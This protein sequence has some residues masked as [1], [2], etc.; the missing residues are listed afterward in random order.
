MWA[1]R[2]NFIRNQ[3][4]TPPPTPGGYNGI[5]NA[6]TNDQG[7]INGVGDINSQ[8]M[9]AVPGTVDFGAGPISFNVGDFT[10]YNGTIW[11]RLAAGSPNPAIIEAGSWDTATNTP[12]LSDSTPV[13]IGTKYVA[14]AAGTVDFGTVDPVFGV[15]GTPFV[16]GDYVIFNGYNWQMVPVGV[17]TPFELVVNTSYSA[18]VELP[19][20]QCNYLTVNWGDGNTEEITTGAPFTHTYGS[21]ATFTVTVHGHSTKYSTTYNPAAQLPIVTVNS[22]GTYGLANMRVAFSG[23]MNL[24][25]VPTYLPPSVKII[26]GMFE[27]ATSFNQ[28]ISAWNTINVTS[29]YG[30]FGGATVFNQPLNTWNTSNITEMGGVFDSATVFNQPLSSW[31]TSKVTN[32]GGMFENA[33]AF[34]QDISMWDTSKVTDMVY[35]FAGA[36]VFNQPLNSWNM[37]S[38]TNIAGMFYGAQAFNHPL[39]LWNTSNVITI[40]LLFMGALAFNQPLNSWDVSSVTSMAATFYNAQAFNQSLNSWNT[41]KV[42]DMNQTFASIGIAGTTIFNQPLSSW[43]VSHVTLMIQMFS[44]SIFNQD[45]SMWNTSKVTTMRAMFEHTHFNQPLNTWNTS[46]VTD[47]A[48]MFDFA[49]VFNQPLNLWNTSRVTDM[50]QM[51]DQAYTFNQD[52]SSWDVHLIPSLPLNFDRGGPLSLPANFAKLP[53]WGV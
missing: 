36:T 52:I 53:H 44:G 51:F 6:A 22:F 33:S 48:G 13:A 19:F 35:M 16:A 4:S 31:N 9:A 3:S 49:T 42:I 17:G 5:W 1:Y 14:T 18:D 26:D 24:T 25:T 30:L 37:S 20:T 47:M 40:D 27:Q 38:V 15:Y 8:F 2:Q 7:L 11:T 39:D 46:S 45:I 50:V 43:D 32:M 10:V 12:A 34:N 21:T 29:M 23:A 41:S 28:N